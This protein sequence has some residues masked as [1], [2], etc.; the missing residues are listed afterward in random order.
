M[1]GVPSDRIRAVEDSPRNV[2]RALETTR[3]RA[4]SMFCESCERLIVGRRADWSSVT[5]LVR[6]SCG[7]GVAY[8]DALALRLLS[9]SFDRPRHSSIQYDHR[10]RC[11]N[12]ANVHE[13]V[14]EWPCTRDFL[15]SDILLRPE[16]ISIAQ[17]RK[18]VRQFHFCV[19]ILGQE[20]SSNSPQI[21]EP[22]GNPS[23]LRIQVAG[24][25]SNPDS[26][27]PQ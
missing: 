17:C 8:P 18:K 7:Q 3:A 9:S 10:K 21:A 20:P 5:C 12:P 4:A 22:Q 24:M 6:P 25:H 1:G 19:P 14:R 23:Q 16:S 13:F 11:G 15:K 27:I 26:S 2:E